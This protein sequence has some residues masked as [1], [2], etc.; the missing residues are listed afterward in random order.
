MDI[1]KISRKKM[2]IFSTIII[3]SIILI[4]VLT[5]LTPK[6]YSQEISSFVSY[7]DF[8]NYLKEQGINDQSNYYLFSTTPRMMESTDGDSLGKASSGSFDDTSYSETNIQVEGVDEPDSVKT[9]GTYIYIL[10]DQTIYIIQA[11]PSSS[12]QIISTISLS[13]DQW[14]QSFFVNNDHLVVFGESSP[15]YWYYPEPL[16][17]KADTSDSTDN[18]DSSNDST[19]NIIYE[20][21]NW[22]VPTVIIEVYDLSDITSPTL[23]TTIE[24]DGIFVNARMIDSQIYIVASEHTSY[25]YRTID[26]ADYFKTPSITIDNIQRNISAEQIYYVDEPDK[27]DSL[28]HILSLNIE[29]LS[30]TQ[31][32]FLIGNTQ[33]IYMSTDHIYLVYS[34]YDYTSTVFN[35]PI[36]DPNRQTTRIHK[37]A[38]DNDEIIHVG[39][40]EVPGRSLN[41]FSM[42]E[43]NS[44]FRIA[45]TTGYIWN[46]ENP[47]QNNV[48]ILDEQ[49]SIVSSIEDIAT[50]E[51][52]YSARFMGDK[53]YLVTFK[54]VDPFFTLDLS[55]PYDPQVLGELKIP[56]YSDY[57]H[58]YD[59]HH[60]IGIG[61]DAIASNNPNFAWYQGVKLALFNVSN[62]NDPVLVDTTIIGDRGSSSPVLYDHKA[63]LFEREKQ[64][65]VLPMSV[66]EIP[67]EQKKGE[68]NPSAHGRFSYQG[69]YVFEITSDGFR[70]RDRITHLNE[71]DL[72]SM[73][74]QYRHYWNTQ[75]FIYRSL[76][77]N[78]VLFTISEKML[79]ANHLETLNEISE[80]LLSP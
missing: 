4:S 77:I 25:L 64:L 19:N 47:S 16:I 61:K 46:E 67:E 80:V 78:D 65:L 28:T 76:Y 35:T 72:E 70:F 52:I 75:A 10:S 3:S 18:A 57:L 27:V 71:T 21:G 45:T 60:I 14:Y 7:E 73:K 59:E 51:E 5:V 1:K 26:K 17:D 20:A 15:T 42:D 41:Q 32:S 22:D 69:A 62:F 40:S 53:A 54:N 63:L 31:K 50:G 29:S 34:S 24:L 48:Y 74:D 11:T 23:Q 2:T 36:N 12:A 37:I 13:K 56:G 79:K 43:H 39:S 55:D 38:V 30:F 33:E 58:P 8:F 49:L 66:Y 6:T 9:D 68:D 44:Y